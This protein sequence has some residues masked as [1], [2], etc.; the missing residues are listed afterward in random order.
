MRPLVVLVDLQNDFL[1]APGL[2]PS[3][4]E[5]TG[6]AARLLE[7]ARRSGIPLAHVALSVDPERD[8]RMPHWKTLGRRLCVRGTRGHEPPEPLR[9]LD[10]EPVISKTDFSA[11][12]SPEMEKLI[13]R[14]GCDTLVLAG[15]H[16]HGCV[17]ATALDAYARRLEV[18]IA[19]DAV[20]SDD[21]VHAA[22]T[23]RYLEDRFVRFAPAHAILRHF[24]A[25]LG[26]AVSGP[27]GAAQDRQTSFSD[28]ES[29]PA[30]VAD[31]RS[32]AGNDLRA[33]FHA[34]PRRHGAL[35]LR[36]PIAGI[37]QTAAAVTS[38]RAAQRRWRLESAA[39]RAATLE[40]VAATLEASTEAIADRM[41]R[42]IGKPIV[43]GAAEIRRAAALVRA[44]V[45]F[46]PQAERVCG[47]DSRS[48]RRPAGVIA[49][50]TPWNN[51][52]AIP[53]G[54]IA[55]ALFYGN[56][57]VWKPAPAAAGVAAFVLELLAAAG[58]PDGVV[59]LVNGDRTT[60]RALLCSP[61]IDAA[62]LSGSSSAGFA[63]QEICAAH[64][65]PLQAELGGN[66]AAVVWDGADLAS[67]ALEVARG[68]FE[69][70]GQR[71]TSNRRVIV[72]RELS[73]EF[74][75]AVE[76]A[77]RSLVWG[78]PVD[79]A[80]QAGP[81]ISE[82]KRSAVAEALE[83]ARADR[84]SVRIAADPSLASALAREGAYHPP[85]IVTD[86]NPRSEIVQEETF[87]PVLVVQ[88]ASDF[89]DAL[90]LANG[91]RQGLVA[92][93]FGGSPGE[94]EEFLEE[95]AAGILK[96]DRSTSDADALAPFGGWKASGV[97]PPEHGIGAREF[98]TREQ[99]VYGRNGT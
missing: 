13:Q 78:D 8:D 56:A 23:V 46:G 28:V 80:T 11:F 30:A 55:P 47:P 96:F 63:V 95:A 50:I 38:A 15:V 73:G 98:F 19:D 24:E 69:F 97:G 70:A 41:A 18:W 9:P 91:V 42:H 12:S 3:A 61:Q 36:V 64:R 74:V 75:D 82:E 60:V 4:G 62:S 81:L 57:V 89:P 99:A 45:S 49:A 43:L 58:V 76:K 86:A 71:C 67:A 1:A 14:V 66:N 35:L 44:A 6:G 77:A 25:G 40:R 2:Q 93:L 83:R 94:R 29:L 26:Q 37:L 59:N 65:I 33:V 48:R 7:G 22:L 92:S 27:P 32:V 53:L 52:V 54:K 88:A 51:P 5:V 68:A 34:S 72:R 17:R 39:A 20:G 21:P 90:A 16:L 85:A 87:G 79:S 10:N 31:G 84:A